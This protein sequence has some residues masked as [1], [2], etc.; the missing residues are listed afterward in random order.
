MLIRH[1]RHQKNLNLNILFNEDFK[2]TMNFIKVN[3]TDTYLNKS[4]DK[5]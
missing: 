3:Y 2:N 1:R 5:Y 4:E